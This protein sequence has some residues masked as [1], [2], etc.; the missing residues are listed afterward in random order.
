MFSIGQHQG[1]QL[2]SDLR[3][4]FGPKDRIHRV[5]RVSLILD[6]LALVGHLFFESRGMLSVGTYEQAFSSEGIHW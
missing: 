2:D 4:Y 6:V 5:H 1:C 3:W